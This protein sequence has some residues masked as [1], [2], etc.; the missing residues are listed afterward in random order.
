MAARIPRNRIGLVAVDGFS[1]PPEL[2]LI[3]TFATREEAEA[4]LAAH[5][6]AD[7]KQ[8]DWIS[9][10]YFLYEGTGEPAAE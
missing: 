8:A 4:A 1:W 9:D 6:G 10:R 2:Y 7:A 5:Q 3:A